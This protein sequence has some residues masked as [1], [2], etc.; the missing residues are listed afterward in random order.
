MAV[1]SSPV[2]GEPEARPFVPD[3]VVVAC[4]KAA[5]DPDWPTMSNRVEEDIWL[6]SSAITLC[7]L[8]VA[9]FLVKP[10]QA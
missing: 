5:G 1:L 3:G 7:E 2:S 8:E 10:S 6:A 4:T 9:V